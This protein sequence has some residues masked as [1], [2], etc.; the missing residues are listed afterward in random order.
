MVV[1]VYKKTKASKKHYMTVFTGEK[2]P[3]RINN[4]NARKPLIPHKYK[5]VEMGMG[6]S[7]IDSWKEKYKIKKHETV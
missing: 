4:L 6:K 5:I 7:F 2:T 1:V 3:D